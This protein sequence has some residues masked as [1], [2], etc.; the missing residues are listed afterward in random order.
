MKKTVKFIDANR[1]RFR[2]DIEIKTASTGKARFSM[3]GEHGGS[4]GQCQDSIKP[5][6]E[7]QQLLLDLWNKYH[8][9]DM[10]PGTPAQMEALKKPVT[11]TELFNASMYIHTVLERN[12]LA[13]GIRKYWKD[14]MDEKMWQHYITVLHSNRMHDGLDPLSDKEVVDADV[15][16]YINDNFNV[17]KVMDEANEFLEDK[18]L[19]KKIAHLQH[20]GLVYDEHPETG[21]DFKYGS[22]WI[23]KDMPDDIE[24]I[25]EDL[26]YDLNEDMQGTPVTEDDLDLFSGFDNDR[27]THALAM[28]LD[29]NH[30]DIEDITE[31]DDYKWCVQGTD[32]YCGDEEEMNE[33][34]EE[35]IE[36]SLWAFNKSFLG[37]YGSLAKMDCDI[38]DKVLDPIQQ[39][40]ESGNEA[41]KGLVDWDENKDEIV[42]DAIR[43]DGR[44]HFLNHWDSTEL[45]YGKYYAYR[46]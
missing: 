15:E 45:S 13:A 25:I 9:N 33:K 37:S 34:T 27:A 17:G 46:C 20:F 31:Y 26:C 22:G 43:S 5:A 36:N 39:E 14:T 11:D 19:N 38:V 6:N 4:C 16:V 18:F 10:Q 44:A 23:Y 28:M 1:N 7:N 29:L 30:E 32:Y 2:V 8:L 12:R 35:Y 42:S 41:V 21:E 3:S 40:C 24:S